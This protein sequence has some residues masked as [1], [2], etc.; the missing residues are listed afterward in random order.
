MP[1][2]LVPAVRV[3]GVGVVLGAEVSCN[4]GHLDLGVVTAPFDGWPFDIVGADGVAEEFAGRSAES[5]AKPVEVLIVEDDTLEAPP[6][7]IDLHLDPGV[8]DLGGRERID[9]G[10]DDPFLQPL[11]DGG[12]MESARDLD[13]AQ[14]RHEQGG[15][16]VALAVAIGER[17]RL[18]GTSS[19]ALYPKSISLRT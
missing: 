12:G 15:L 3:E 4:S 17:T 7:V 2:R 8:E 5:A 6:F 18:A 11:V 16:G 14:E 10:G 1:L 13:C 19:S 9:D